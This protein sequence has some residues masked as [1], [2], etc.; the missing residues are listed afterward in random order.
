LKLVVALGA[1]KRKNSSFARHYDQIRFRFHTAWVK[2]GYGGRSTGM[3]AVPQTADDFGASRKSAQ[4]GQ[5]RDEAE[6]LHR[7]ACG[8]GLV[9]AVL[10]AFRA[11]EE[12]RISC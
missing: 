10:A 9:V 3:S 12:A 5:N 6:G 2:S 11:R 4:V 7:G 8:H 1:K